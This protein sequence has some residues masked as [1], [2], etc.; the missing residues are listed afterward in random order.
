MSSPIQE[1]AFSRRRGRPRVRQRQLPVTLNLPP[2]YLERI[3]SLAN[4]QDV[5]VSKILRYIV[6][7]HLD[8]R[9][10]KTD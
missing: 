6:V 4:K 9:I 2:A 5:K 1:I 7:T 3:Y 8:G 10:K